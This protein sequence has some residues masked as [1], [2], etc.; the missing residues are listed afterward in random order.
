ML[1]A[2]ANHLAVMFNCRGQIIYCNGHFVRIAG[3]SIDQVLGHCWNEVF[4][5]SREAESASNC[6]DLFE[7]N[8]EQSHQ[9]NELLSQAGDHYRIRWHTIS[10][11]G[12]SGVKV[13]VAG[14]G[15]DV[16]RGEVG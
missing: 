10:L 16:T 7:A 1:T 12:P 14:I 5:L 2:S 3:L 8:A 4:A 9:E 11:R 13:C 6:W 15:E